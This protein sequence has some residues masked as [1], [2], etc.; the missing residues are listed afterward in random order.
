M[1]DHLR[2]H[3]ANHTA[4]DSAVLRDLPTPLRR[5]VLR[6]LYLDQLTHTSLFR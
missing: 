4:S 1:Q 2:L 3:F 5:R 6:F